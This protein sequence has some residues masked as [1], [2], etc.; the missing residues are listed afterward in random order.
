M[1]R[2]TEIQTNT[3]TYTPTQTHMDMRGNTPPHL[4]VRERKGSFCLTTLV[5]DTDHVTG[6]STDSLLPNKDSHNQ[7]K[8]KRKNLL[9]FHLLLEA[10]A[11]I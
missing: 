6:Q 4:E 3:H 11:Y 1:D 7:W 2:Q 10:F 9:P 8:D 5:V